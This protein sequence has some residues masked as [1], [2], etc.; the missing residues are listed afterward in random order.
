MILLN[1]LNKMD[2]SCVVKLGGQRQYKL[3]LASCISPAGE[4]PDPVYNVGRNLHI[5]GR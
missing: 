3:P 2:L 4:S 5:F 1:L